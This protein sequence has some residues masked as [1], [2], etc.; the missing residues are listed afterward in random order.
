ML[1]RFN[2]TKN[3]KKRKVGWTALVGAVQEYRMQM[4]NLLIPVIVDDFIGTVEIRIGGVMMEKGE[5]KKLKEF[6]NKVELSDTNKYK[7]SLIESVVGLKGLHLVGE[8]LKSSRIPL[9][10]AMI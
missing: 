9:L 10:M 2:I 5:I 6:V 1:A 3:A 8:T 4:E 7:N